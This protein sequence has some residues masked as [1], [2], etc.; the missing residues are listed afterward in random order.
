MA[1]SEQGQL[2]KESRF[3]FAVGPA[4]LA[5][6][7]PLA[8]FL[9]AG[10]QSS[11]SVG[12]SPD[13]ATGAT[14]SKV[15]DGDTIEIVLNRKNLRVRLLGVDAPESVHPQ[16]PIQCF[17]QEASTA[18]SNLLPPGTQVEIERDVQAQDH[19]DR[20]LLYV[21]R[22]DDG[23]FVNQ[24]LVENGLA[25]ESHYEP[26]VA[27]R[28][29]LRQAKRRARSGSIGLWGSCDGPDQPIG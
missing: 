7:F 4:L 1:E 29:M 19:F 8:I 3:G 27:K 9:L 11:D 18:L 17:G 23:L 21:Y 10:C 28:T 14:V 5:G 6:L 12:S 26:N 16:L 22:A 15:I 13:L 24:W 2:S 25:D 20:F